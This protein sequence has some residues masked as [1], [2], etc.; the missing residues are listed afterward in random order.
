MGQVTSLFL[1]KVMNAFEGDIDKSELLSAAGIAPEKP[2]DP[3]FMV[4]S[5]DYYAAFEKL[6]KAYRLFRPSPSTCV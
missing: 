5:T 3:S 4:S 6:A 2:V 1:T